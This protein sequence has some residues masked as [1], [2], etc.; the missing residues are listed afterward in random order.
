MPYQNVW[1]NQ[2]KKSKYY[3]NDESIFAF[4]LFLGKIISGYIIKVI[5]KFTSR[6]QSKLD[7]KIIQAFQKPLRYFIIFFGS[8]LALIYLPL[9][10]AQD[11]FVY[12][13]FRT[14]I[15]ILLAWGFYEL[16]GTHS[17]ISDE[18]KA[19]L[20]IDDILLLPRVVSQKILNFQALKGQFY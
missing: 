11:L 2:C 20:K 5:L 10:T 3:F 18:M 19:K 13:I 8:Y 1:N 14:A 12:K 9:S 15:I 7:N 6:N 17:A 16:A 4:F